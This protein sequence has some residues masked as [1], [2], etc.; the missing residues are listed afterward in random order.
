[1]V[2][3]LFE[4]LFEVMMMMMDDDRKQLQQAQPR[5]RLMTPKSTQINQSNQL[6]QRFRHCLK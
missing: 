5:K 4:V 2:Q 3:T 1:M 6:N